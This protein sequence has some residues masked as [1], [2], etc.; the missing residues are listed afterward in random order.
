VLNKQK[1][2]LS[3]QEKSVVSGLL[4][5]YKELMCCA[6]CGSIDITFPPTN[7]DA[8]IGAGSLP[9]RYYCRECE[10]EG[11]PLLFDKLS[12]YEKFY[13]LRR[14]KYNKGEDLLVA[15][16][17]LSG[18]F[19]SEPVKKPYVAALL[20]LLIPGLGQAYNGE[21]DK[22]QVIFFVF[23]MLSLFIPV[24]LFLMDQI[25]IVPLSVTGVMLLA[26]YALIDAY[27]VAK[28]KK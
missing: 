11:L 26:V 7:V 4:K 3:G 17:L 19:G 21:K 22:A 10:Y 9:R 5:K 20:S 14:E 16:R 12:S 15:D 1:T 24:F 18:K 23:L 8:L 28:T 25:A 6:N 27:I 13:S 2:H